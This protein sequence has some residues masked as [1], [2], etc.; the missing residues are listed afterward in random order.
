MSVQSAK[1]DD[2]IEAY[3]TDVMKQLPMRQRNDV[4]FEL[5]ALLM[6]ELSGRAADG[7]RLLD[8]AMTLELLR[9]FG[10]PDDVAA[11]YHPVGIPVIPANGTR[12][13]AWLTFVGIALQWAV[14]L[15]TAIGSGEPNWVGRWWLT[16]GLGA[17]WW[18]GLLVTLTMIA[19]FIRQ[20]WP[21]KGEA[22]SPKLVDRGYVNRPLFLLG[23]V[24][25]LAG[26][27]L[28]VALAWWATT[29]TADTPLARVFA[30]EA[31]FL[32][33]RAPV[34]LLYWAINI[35][36]IGVVIS[37]GRWRRLTRRIDVGLKLACCIMLA[38]ILFS[39]N[40]FVAETTNGP[41][42]GI[43]SLLIVVVLADLGWKLWRGRK[44][45]YVPKDVAAQHGGRPC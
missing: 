41:A 42:V 17:L 25:A 38:W 5:R 32:A 7:G 3:V 15:P 44:Q 6:E 10:H 35:V 11:R 18:P 14:S 27:G 20:R 45:I 34:V 28:W 8:G 2:L 30:F 43:L 39:G 24:A 1:P 31:D 26:V 33:T 12:M 29:T 40:V 19:A 21:A 36:L 13:F 16:G 4:G 9:A 37:E 23:L 22:W